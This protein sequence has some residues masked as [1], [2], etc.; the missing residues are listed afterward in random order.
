[1]AAV[2]VAGA[3]GGCGGAS[4]QD[5]VRAKIAQFVSAAAAR[6][7]ATICN[8]V[9]APS[10]LT[11]LAAGGISCPQAM[12]IGFGG[13]S[14][15]TLSIGKITVS[16][17]HAAVIALSTAQGQPASLDTVELTRTGQGWRIVSLGTPPVAGPGR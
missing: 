3:L 17:S 12:Q 6:D 15:P 1:M 13:V 11:R 7:Y 10:L 4:Q 8:Q 16:G 14:R 5:Q 2:A 9:L